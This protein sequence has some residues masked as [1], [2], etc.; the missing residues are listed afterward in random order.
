MPGQLA[1]DEAALRLGRPVEIEEIASN[2]TLEERIATDGPWDLIFPSDYLVERL[3]RGGR[4]IRLDHSVVPVD[5]L[6]QWARDCQFDRGNTVSVPF[7]YG[8]TGFLT[9][10]KMAEADSWADLFLP[11]EGCRVGMLDEAREVVG[12]ALIASGFDANDVTDQALAAAQALL[13]AQA[14]F[15]AR[16]ASDDFTGPVVAG[17]VAAHQAWSGPA[18]RAMRQSGGLRYVLPQEGAT[19]WVTCAAVLAEASEPLV[20]QA[21]IRE[22][23]DPALA[24]STTEVGGYAT[25]NAE[26]LTIL[27]RALR[28]DPVLFPSDSVLMRCTTLRDLGVDEKKAVDTFSSV[29]DD[30]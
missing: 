1:I 28:E 25:A 17:D 13:A 7:A 30:H 26:A 19:M 9:G 14:P 11:P 27:P 24:A 15:V 21:L 22:L 4:L 10:A 18:S 23:M 12:A 20:S 29:R 6:A 2:E 3:K 5:R 8:T 16:Y